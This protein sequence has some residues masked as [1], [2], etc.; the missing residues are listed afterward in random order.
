[1]QP[2]TDLGN[3][4]YFTTSAQHANNLIPNLCKR[5]LKE[6]Y[7]QKKSTKINVAVRIEPL[8]VLETTS[9]GQLASSFDGWIASG[10]V[11]HLYA[12]GFPTHLADWM[13]FLK[14]FTHAIDVTVSK[15]VS[16]LDFVSV[17]RGIL[18]TYVREM[19][20][21]LS[22]QLPRKLHRKLQVQVVFVSVQKH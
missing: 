20:N 15:I 12:S 5:S 11:H 10:Q 3:A 18:A 2:L 8:R 22:M 17:T 13:L 16:H 4:I 19:S 21:F 9:L 7:Y 14:C 6:G 1:M